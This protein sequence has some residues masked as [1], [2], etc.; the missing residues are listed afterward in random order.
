LSAT[1]DIETR[2]QTTLNVASPVAPSNT[3]VGRDPEQEPPAKAGARVEGSNN[4]ARRRE[5]TLARRA[6]PSA[7]VKM[8]SFLFR[9]V[10]R[11]WVTFLYELTG[12]LPATLNGP[13]AQRDVFFL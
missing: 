9:G 6:A 8:L 1:I 4:A 2:E 3:P 5:Q 12:R 13:H 7:S 10:K 11:P